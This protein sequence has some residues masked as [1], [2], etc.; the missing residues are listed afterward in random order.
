MLN[1]ALLGLLLS[2][3]GNRL[4]AE[5]IRDVD[6]KDAVKDIDED[7]LAWHLVPG[8]FNRNASG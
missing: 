3:P 8:L 6:T 5:L 2:Q 4:R 1:S 7:V